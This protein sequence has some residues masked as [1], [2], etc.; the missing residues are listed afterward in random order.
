[1]DPSKEIF[2]SPHYYGFGSGHDLIMK[3]FSN[4][5]D[6][7]YYNCGKSYEG[8]LG[9]MVNNSKNLGLSVKTNKFIVNE[10]EAF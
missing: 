2:A 5:I 4:R 3:D 6:S 1:M 9:L 10:I 8:H 7:S